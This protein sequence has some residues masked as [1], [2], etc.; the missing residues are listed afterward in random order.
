M[1]GF[2]ASGDLCFGDA[3]EFAYPYD[4][5]G[6]ERAGV[7]FITVAEIY[8]VNL[9]ASAEG[10]ESSATFP[11][12]DTPLDDASATEPLY[13]ASEEWAT[14]AGDVPPNQPFDGRLREFRFGRSLLSGS[15]FG[16]LALGSGALSFDNSDGA[17]DS[18][19]TGYALDGR[20]VVVRMGRS[21]DAYDSF[22]TLFDGT[23]RDWRGTVA[24]V[25]IIL[26]DSGFRLDVP[27]QPETYAG[28]GG[29]AGGDDLAGKRK[30]LLVGLV[31]HGPL[32]PVAPAN[33]IYQANGGAIAAG[34]E[35]LD[36][37][38]PLTPGG[39]PQA[40]YAA[41]VA[42]T[43]AAGTFEVY[44]AGGYVKLGAAPAGQ[45][46]FR[47]AEGFAL[48][49]TG[50]IVRKLIATSSL[51]D[52]Q[53]I[54]AA[55][56]TALDTAQ[57]ADVGIFIGTDATPTV[58][59]AVADVLAGIGAFGAFDRHGKLFVDRVEPPGGATDD[60]FGRHD[61]IALDRDALP[62]ALSPPPWRMRTTYRRNY[63]QLSGGDVSGAVA[64]ADRAALG[65][66]TLVAQ[67]SDPD[68][69]ARYLLAQ[70]LAP[71]RSFF[72][73]KADAE[74]EAA[75]LLFLY[76]AGRALWRAQLP[77]R[78]L[79]VELGRPI[80]LAYPRFGLADGRAMTAVEVSMSVGA[81]SVIAEVVAYG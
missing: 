31:R 28:T 54:D 79:L 2:G 70:D 4:V 22:V 68:I 12:G 37:G 26:R 53:E 15:R 72:A 80:E 77:R 39:S 35:V 33:L 44:L 81:R 48:D 66:E 13:L 8:P 43:V 40:S 69:L 41:L 7:R 63:A 23:A 74:A 47:A 61:I 11:I 17:Y 19:V 25:E 67:A 30:P 71:E 1:A 14:A 59:D 3:L 73:L 18:F 5:L 9:G 60:S 75:R 27:A 62:A 65:A 51:R 10:V 29:D 50:E 21:T 57:P 20:R 64:T 24:A 56:F 45:V 6:D 42:H 55:T 34:I 76:A 58:A 78:A 52:P 46:T 16:G 38:A 32:A 49:T 36:Q